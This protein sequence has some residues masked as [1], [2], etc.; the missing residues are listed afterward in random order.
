M[1][2]RVIE[3]NH[4]LAKAN[5]DLGKAS[6]YVKMKSQ[7]RNAGSGIELIYNEATEAHK[8]TIWDSMGLDV[9]IKDIPI[10]DQADYLVM[11][12]S[13]PNGAT[14]VFVKDD[15]WCKVE[16]SKTEGNL[17][18]L[19][20]GDDR[21]KVEEL[22][23][24]LKSQCPE[25][26]ESE[27]EIALDFWSWRGS[28]ASSA[29]R[30]VEVPAWDDIKDNYTRSV[31]DK[32]TPIMEKND[33]S[34]SDSGQL[35]LWYGEP[36]TGKTYALRS[37]ANEWREWCDFQYITDPDQFFGTAGYM[38]DVLLGGSEDKWR[39]FILEDSGELLSSDASQRT[40]QGLSRLLNTVDGLIGQGL[41]IMVI[42]TT[43]EPLGALH[44]ALS[45]PGRCLSQIEFKP[46][47]AEETQA[48]LEKHNAGPVWESRTLVD[49]YGKIKDFEKKPDKKKLGFG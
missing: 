9:A 6:G 33:P 10:W 43:N 38:M 44:A 21:T 22:L 5:G 37:L 30:K 3:E 23:H 17:S 35:I 26:E 36:G 42:V 28:Y 2:R 12:A 27:E 48:W 20:A 49:L 4:S 31:L 46:L 34:D 29:R 14:A 25:P 45:R 24:S 7:V 13:N 47:T 39:C 1:H 40:G 15:C 32:L 41:K 16:A 8:Y 11:K 18:F 19:C